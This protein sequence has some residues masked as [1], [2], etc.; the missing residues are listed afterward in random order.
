MGGNDNINGGDGNDYLDG[1]AAT[2]TSTAMQVTTALIGGAGKDMLKGGTGN[3][4]YIYGSD[5]TIIDNQG[6]NTLKFSDDL[7]VSD[8][9]V[10]VIDNADGSKNGK[11]HPPTAL[12]PF[13]TK[14]TPKDIFPSTNSNSSAKTIQPKPCYKAVNTGKADQGIKM[15]AH[16]TTM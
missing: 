6:N 5:D 3:D 11:S 16:R 15:K 13:K 12:P 14:L 2:T 9:K 8:I 1:G 4:T 7:R 10:N